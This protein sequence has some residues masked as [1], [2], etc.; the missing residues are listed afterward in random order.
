MFEARAVKQQQATRSTKPWCASNA[1]PA[2]TAS[3]TIAKPK[4]MFGR[5]S[6]LTGRKLYFD[7]YIT[8]RPLA[9]RIQIT[10][11]MF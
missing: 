1:P 3:A 11:V 9:W 8:L 2:D 5:K 10:N 4:G 7:M 6:T